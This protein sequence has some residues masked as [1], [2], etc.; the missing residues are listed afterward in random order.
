MGNNQDSI[1]LIDDVP[2][3]ECI[4]NVCNSHGEAFIDFLHEARMLITNGRVAGKNTF[5]SI[6]ARGSSVVDY[7]AVSQDDFK[8]CISCNVSPVNE[9][10]SNNHLESMLS[11]R[12]RAPD[13]SLISLSYRITSM[14]YP[15]YEENQDQNQQNE[16]IN[17]RYNY[18]TMSENFMNSPSRLSILDTLISRLQSNEKSQTSIDSFYDEM[19]KEIFEEMDG[20]I[21]YK[22]ASKKSK[23]HYKNHKPFWNDELTAFWKNMAQA[24]KE[25]LKFKNTPRRNILHKKFTTK[26]KLFDK[27]LRNTK[28]SYYRKKL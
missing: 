28:R 13:H 25:Y 6:S 2:E 4:D 22:N 19:L 15:I 5:T 10:I 20:H 23:K 8:N 12:C 1:S 17:K 11:E 18:G 14:D 27:L 7:F 26:R 16:N 21:M 24:E 9:I 3:R